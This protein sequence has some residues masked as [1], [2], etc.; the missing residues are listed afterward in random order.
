M[1]KLENI[2][3]ELTIDDASEIC[4][5]EEADTESPADDEVD[6]DS[7]ENHRSVSVIMQELQ[8]ELE[9]PVMEVKTL[10]FSLCTT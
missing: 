1:E 9:R 7:V 5:E 8:K 6:A 2:I 4:K 10:F 3:D